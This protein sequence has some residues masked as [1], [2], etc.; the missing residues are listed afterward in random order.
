MLRKEVFRE[1]DI[2][3][4]V[5]QD[6]S[7]EN[8]FVFGKAL[9]KY[10]GGTG[11]KLCVGNDNRLSS[12]AIKKALIEGLVS[13]GCNV[14]DLGEVP[15]PAYYFALYELKADGGAYVTASHNPPEY[16]GFKVNKGTESVFGKGIQ[17]IRLI[18][19]KYEFPQTESDKEGKL[20][21]YDI[22]EDYYASL[23][24]AV[25][26]N[27]KRK[28]RLAIDC[29]NGT[30]STF[31]PEFLKKI[32]CEVTELYCDSDGNFP[33]HH[34]DPTKP[35]NLKKLIEIVKKENLD[36]GAAYDGDGD[37]LGIV[38]NK[39]NI[40]W[41]DQLMI[42]FARDFLSKEENHGKKVLVEV[43]CSQGLYE[44]IKKYR[45]IPLFTATGHA[46]IKDRMNREGIDISGEMSGHMFFK[47]KYYGFDDA[48]YATCRLLEI[49]SNQDKEKDKKKLSEIAETFPK[50]YSSPE[51][52]VDCPD[53]KKFEAVKSIKEEFKNKY[54]IIDIDG[55][56]FSTPDGWGLIRASNTQ[57]ILVVR[58]ESKTK[59]GLDKLKKIIDEAVKKHV[60]NAL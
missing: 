8:V 32:G 26:I 54:D 48:L 14:I 23:N 1:Y 56:R 11:K 20:T 35:D 33:N 15:A 51:I 3:G 17:D 37:R 46:L 58:Y 6:F 52:R 42:I 43:K 2:R 7:N 50:Y 60:G 19:E 25:T 27:S 44:E 18:M 38:D 53:E 10:L 13:V 22:K 31:Y 57:E 39:G 55:V 45:G 4:F 36:L 5:K 59:E 12:P 16:N 49:L 21:F 41:G 34:P 9:G 24:R 40:L 30:A 47:D 29:G 28:L